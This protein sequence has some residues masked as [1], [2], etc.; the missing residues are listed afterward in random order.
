MIELKRVIEKD[1]L[2]LWKIQKESFELDLQKNIDFSPATETLE[3]F[4][5]KIKSNL[6]Y[7]IYYESIL[8]GGICIREYKRNSTWKIS[9]IFILPLYQSKGFGSCV[10]KMIE[11]I[12]KDVNFW[13]LETPENNVKSQKFYEKNGFKKNGLVSA[14]NTLKTIY[15][16]KDKI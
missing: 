9:R 6:F 7:S 3:K 16:K 15:Y 11:E 1:L 8:I 13:I 10:L 14:S 2:K 12:H 5:E 4:T